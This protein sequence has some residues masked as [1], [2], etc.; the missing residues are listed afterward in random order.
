V[1]SN[2]EW[3][4]ILTDAIEKSV[5]E[6]GYSTTASTGVSSSI[7]A[8]EL[9]LKMNDAMKIINGDRD[10]RKALIKENEAIQRDW[11]KRFNSEV[12]KIVRKAIH[13]G[14]V[15]VMVYEP[16]KFVDPDEDLAK[17]SVRPIKTMTVR[18]DKYRKDAYQNV[19]EQAENAVRVN[20]PPPKLHRIPVYPVSP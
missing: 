11:D 13:R 6:V 17:Q 10:Q 3:S 12:L 7:T 15:Q 20:M 14:M 8:D 9:I 1:S 16:M 2:S 4:K 5:S 18:Y 19:R